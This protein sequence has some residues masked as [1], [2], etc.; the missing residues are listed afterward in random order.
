MNE[1]GW[2]ESTIAGLLLMPPTRNNFIHL[3]E[4]LR[5]VYKKNRLNKDQLYSLLCPT[6]YPR[7]FSL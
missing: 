6:K 7:I 4:A 2:L 3:N 5:I 1:E